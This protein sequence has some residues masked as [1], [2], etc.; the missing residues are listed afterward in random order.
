MTVAR[1][2]G[3]VRP[4]PGPRRPGR[5]GRRWW[6]LAAGGVLLAGLAVLAVLSATYQPIAY[7][8][9]GNTEEAFSGL[10]TGHGI[11]AVNDFGWLSEDI[12]IP[13]QR[14]TFS[15]FADIANNGTFPITIESAW[16]APGGP[17]SRT[18]AVP[19]GLQGDRLIVRS[20]GGHPGQPGVVC[21]R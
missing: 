11:H 4:S 6:L 3:A 16:L 20:V 2:R 21:A 8:S 9:V 19:W 1:A 7:G 18:T 15:L 17:F 10:P 14:G 5:P 12:F 13:P